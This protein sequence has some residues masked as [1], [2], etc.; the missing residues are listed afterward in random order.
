MTAGFGEV[1]LLAALPAAG[2]VVGGLLA[3]IFRVSERFLSIAL[4]FAAG[5]VLAVVGLELMP[6]ALEVQHAWLPIG[7]FV[8]GAA[9]FVA[10]ER[11]LEFV[12]AR[13]ASEDA[14]PGPMAI[15]VGVSFDLF[16][17]GIM[18]G[19]A[20]VLSPALGLL[21]AAGQ[22]VADIPEG[23]AAVATLRAGGVRRSRRIALA[24]A[25]TLPVVAGAA[26][27]YF[28]LRAAHELAVVS[29]LALTAG[30]L[31]TVVVEE[32][33]PHAHRGETSLY[34]GLFLAAGFALFAATTVYL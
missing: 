30:A 23:F 22:V 7:A 5:V 20:T 25:F 17:D 4:H 29:V 13:L 21:L 16:S 2:N 10:I 27:G 24:F 34:G 33:I 26:I 18:I 8:A 12:H 3:E 14:A 9:I 11:L 31:V 6:R 15:F 1:L 28:T 19:A 32:M